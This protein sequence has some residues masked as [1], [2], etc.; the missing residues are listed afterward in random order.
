[1]LTELEKSLIK[2]E[3]T[4]CS[5]TYHPLPVVLKKGKGV[6]VWDI[7]DKK[8]FDF[9]S[10]YSAVNQGH[11]NEKILNTF[12]K[13]AKKLTLTSRAFYN[14]ELGSSLEYI[15]D[16]FGYEKMLPMNSGAE[17]VETAIK[18]CRK[19][20]YEIKKV[21]HNRA[22]I[23][24][25]DGNFHGRTTTVVSF[26]SHNGS[27]ENFGPLTDGFEI[28]SY[29]N[30]LELEKKLKEDSNIVGF[31][32][33]PIQGE[34]GVVVP[35]NGYLK[36]CKI[37]CEQYNV[38]L[39]VDEI[40]TGVCRTG[41][42]LASYHENIKPDIVILGKALSGGFYPV[43]GVLT[44]KEIMSVMKVGEHGS[45]FGGNPLACVV[46]K[47]AIKYS[48][49]NNLSEK[50][51]KLGNIFRNYLNEVKDEIRIMKT[52]R[53]KGLLNAIVL[54]CKGDSEIPW[55]ICLDMRDNGLIAK[56]T[57]G[58]KIRFAPPLVIKEKEMLEALKIIEKSLRKF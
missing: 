8:Y 18:I 7:H 28:I 32:V 16:T 57:Q 14:N 30:T 33:E 27:K 40:Q 11:C 17:A 9:L 43:S 41:K 52:V 2:K 48:I 5:N 25:C 56:P 36:K 46:A 47:E 38:L 12:I 1:M 31:L 58:N 42:L 21:D 20:G 35:D 22:K 6:Y 44:S 3:E 10:A 23:L 50:A 15:T 49:D 45:T 4:F 51:D 26:S 55:N 39:L 53:G 19:W 37:L 24:V 54:N 13:Q 29:N 34:G